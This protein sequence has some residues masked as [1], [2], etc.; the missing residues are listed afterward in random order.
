MSEMQ[1]G[2]TVHSYD[3][4]MSQLDSELLR[5]GEM[6]LAQLDLTI[7]ALAFDAEVARQVVLG[8]RSI[9]EL[10]FHIQHRAFDIIAKR[11]P[12]ARDLRFVVS[13]MRIAA[14]LERMADLAENV[15]KRVMV[16]IE[17]GEQPSTVGLVELAE[18]VMGQVERVMG[19]EVRDDAEMTRTL[20]LDD[21]ETDELYN[22]LVKQSLEEL[23][24]TP[25]RIQAGVHVL[26]MAKSL[27]RIGDLVTNVAEHL[28]FQITGD[29]LQGVRPQ[30]DETGHERSL[31]GVPADS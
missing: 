29:P 27:E 24:Q 12:I 31:H 6:T 3:Q 30:V 22:D 10:E 14:D 5:L 2:H 17:L 26:A 11:Q 18:R 4:D 20:W 1:R 9:D 23:A 15:A 13:A 19:A 21:R 16:L 25:D 8:D 7:K 28:H